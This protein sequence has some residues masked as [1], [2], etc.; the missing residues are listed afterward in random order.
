MTFSQLLSWFAQG[1]LFI[2]ALVPA[3]GGHEGVLVSSSRQGWERCL[4]MSPKQHPHLS[5]WFSPA[6]DAGVSTE[7]ETRLVARP[8]LLWTTPSP[9]SGVLAVGQDSGSCSFSQEL[10][11]LDEKVTS[12]STLGLTPARFI[13]TSAVPTAALL[14]VACLLWCVFGRALC[15]W[16]VWLRTLYR[17]TTEWTKL[18]HTSTHR[19]FI[20]RWD[21]VVSQRDLWGGQC[22]VPSAFLCT[23]LK[24]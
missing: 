21:E 3:E 9:H 18:V 12:N 4:S 19:F 11:R 15:S 13:K 17:V 10:P 8:R 23:Y 20:L 7:Q 1:C 2:Y 14:G 6:A 22:L 24:I 5:R 16:L